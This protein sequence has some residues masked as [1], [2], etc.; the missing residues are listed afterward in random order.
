M[1]STLDAAVRALE[2]RL[3][4]AFPDTPIAWPNVEFSA[5]PGA[6]YLRP[7]VLWGAAD[8]FTMAP[9]KSNRV[10]G[11]YQV[12]V[13]S[14][15]AVGAGPALDLSDQVRSAYNRAVFNGVRCDAPGG[16][17]TLDEEPPWYGLAISIPFAVVEDTA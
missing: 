14:P 12:N 17:A 8:L 3:M 6:C 10:L 5:P 15:L 9:S 2:T 4:A 16:P 7:W 13:Y 11:I 1:P